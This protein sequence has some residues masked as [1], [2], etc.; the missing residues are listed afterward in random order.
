MGVSD[1]L[2][3]FASAVIPQSPAGEEKH[4]AS[5]WLDRFEKEI[6]VNAQEIKIMF[7]PPGS[8]P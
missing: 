7:L 6:G 2:H 4:G 8:F 3:P 1:L 5:A